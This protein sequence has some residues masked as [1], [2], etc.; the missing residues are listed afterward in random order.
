[1]HRKPRPSTNL[2]ILVVATALL[3]LFNCKH[4]HMEMVMGPR[5]R[6]VIR[7][8]NSV[9]A[10]RIV[11]PL[12]P[13]YEQA[14]RSRP[15]IDEYPIL[16]ESQVS[17]QKAAEIATILLDDE[18]FDPADALDCV[19]DPGYVV[20]FRKDRSI[21]NVVFCFKCNDLDI[22]PSQDLGERAVTYPFGKVAKNLYTRVRASIAPNGRPAD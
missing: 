12:A 8:P 15:M 6:E 10:Y 20:S 9:I 11:S 5:T 16:S 17:R 21:V 4:R 1:V 19:F 3:L 2:R 22:V 7:R 13:E 14:R 18:R